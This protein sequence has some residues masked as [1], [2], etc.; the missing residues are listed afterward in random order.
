MVAMQDS[1]LI[2]EPSK[3]GWKT[4]ESLKG[5]SQCVAFDPSNPNLDVW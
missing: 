4:R 2:V 1:L 5:T 3:T